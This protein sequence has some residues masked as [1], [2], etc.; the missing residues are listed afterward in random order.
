MIGNLQEWC[1]DKLSR[2]DWPTRPGD[3]LREGVEKV[4]IAVRDGSMTSTAQFA[5]S[6]M[7][8]PLGPGTRLGHV[9]F[10]ASRAL[11]AR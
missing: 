10:R 8:T 4:R 2:Y 1:R 9:G 6:S 7:R 5:K 3:G 11:R